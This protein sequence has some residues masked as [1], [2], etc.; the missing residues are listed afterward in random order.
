MGAILTAETSRVAKAI[1]TP[2]NEHPLKKARRSILA[3]VEGQLRQGLAHN[4]ARALAQIE[5]LVRDGYGEDII[6][7]LNAS[8]VLA[9]A[10]EAEQ[11]GPTGTDRSKALYALIKE[12]KV[13]TYKP[14]IGKCRQ[15]PAKPR[16]AW[17][18]RDMDKLGA[19]AR[20]RARRAAR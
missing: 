6:I 19:A 15:K 18:D 14:A 20:K 2:S 1:Q 13:P 8:G 9:E 7:M 12:Q 3:Q 17:T 4:R 16:S 5:R 11:R 10:E